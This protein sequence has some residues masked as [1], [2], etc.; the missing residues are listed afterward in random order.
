[1][2]DQDLDLGALDEMDIPD[3]DIENNQP[4]E[5]EGCEGGACKI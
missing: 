4:A 3:V 5:D 2:S 1:M